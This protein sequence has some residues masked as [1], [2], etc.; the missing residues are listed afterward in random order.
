MDLFDLNPNENKE[1]SN[2]AAMAARQL[3]DVRS[4][5]AKVNPGSDMFARLDD[6]I[7]RLQAAARTG[8]GL[9]TV[10]IPS[11]AKI[12]SIRDRLMNSAA[13]ISDA[14]ASE[15]KNL[16]KVTEKGNLQRPFQTIWSLPGVLRACH[17]D[18][19]SEALDLA[20]QHLPEINHRLVRL[21]NAERERLVLR[22]AVDTRLVH[23]E[24]AAIKRLADVVNGYA[25]D[26]RADALADEHDN[27]A[28][29]THRIVRFEQALKNATSVADFS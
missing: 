19:D 24:L 3:T 4:V 18:S 8:S 1:L 22:G 23:P 7:E 6:R 29:R 5:L 20:I 27:D 15:T 14:V 13:R 16:K 12:L 11:P 21:A 26:L 25:R 2:R 28:L 9:A 17:H 10:T